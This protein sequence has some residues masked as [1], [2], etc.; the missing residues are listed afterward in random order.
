MEEQLVQL[1][2]T[3]NDALKSGLTEAPILAQTI[4]IDYKKYSL[5]RAV[6][7]LFYAVFLGGG[8]FLG[9][10]YFFLKNEW[11]EVN[12]AT[13]LVGLGSAVIGTVTI[14]ASF[15]QAFESITA[16]VAPLGHLF[17]KAL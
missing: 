11:S 2:M 10:F 5:M 17:Q 6:T 15:A 8:L 12:A 16:Y 9:G 14:L 13:K 3:L 7:E 4:L 1:I